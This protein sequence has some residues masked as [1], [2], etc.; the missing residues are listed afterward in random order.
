M[1]LVTRK[2]QHLGET[3]TVYGQSEYTGIHALASVANS[4]A[5]AGASCLGVGVRIDYPLHTNK[6]NIYKM[7]KNIK[8]VCK[9]RQIELLESNLYANPM[10]QIPAVTVTGIAKAPKEEEW[11]RDK[12]RAGKEIVLSKWTGMAGMLQIAQERKEVLKGRFAP[13]FMR[14]I[15]SHR[16]ELF[17]DR[18]IAVAKAMGVSVMRQVTEGGIFAAFWDIAKE[19]KVGLE[20]D[21]KKI[22]ILQET[23]EVCE[24][25]R[26]NPYQLNSTGSFLL[27]SDDGE[28]L[29]DALKQEHI[30]AAV[31]GC[32]TDNQDKIIRNGEDIRYIDRPAPDEIFKIYVGGTKNE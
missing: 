13:D 22:L 29:A 19:L 32:T 10:V 6:S 23:V 16:Q 20:L 11:C 24:H 28:A 3:S 25:F 17:A 18:E 9:E 31:I 2:E 21:M 7:E 12:G 15:F 27:L 14:Q 26:I 4:L 8:K 5:A 30:E 1:K